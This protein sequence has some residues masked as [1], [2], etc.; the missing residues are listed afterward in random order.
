ML[1]N[2]YRF[3]FFLNVKKIVEDS[4]SFCLCDLY[5]LIF[6]ILEIKTEKLGSLGG[7]A[8]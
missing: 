7:A 3:N 5:F 4:K 6:T 1:V 2:E 8:V